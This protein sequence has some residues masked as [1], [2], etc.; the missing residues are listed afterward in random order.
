[1]YDDAVRSDD[2]LPKAIYKCTLCEGKP[3]MVAVDP[4]DRHWRALDDHW[5][6]EHFTHTRSATGLRFLVVRDLDEIRAAHVPG[7][8]LIPYMYVCRNCSAT[9]TAEK[10]ADVRPK[11]LEHLKNHHLDLVRRAGPMH[12]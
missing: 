10:E 3:F 8:G 11:L 7:V 12:P 1:M 5:R 6:S 4:F 2:K 9:L